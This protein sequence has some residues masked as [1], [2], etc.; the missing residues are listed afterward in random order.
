MS[1]I[2]AVFEHWYA[3]TALHSSDSPSLPM[4]SK[5]PRQAAL[6]FF[7]VA[8]SLYLNYSLIEVAK[9]VKH[10]RALKKHANVEK[11]RPEDSYCRFSLLHAALT[12]TQY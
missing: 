9:Q 10:A 6:L 5:E 4:L 8:V 1:R 12:A 2:I 11:I 3:T 7:L